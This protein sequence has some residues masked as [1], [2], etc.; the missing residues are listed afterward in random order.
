MNEAEAKKITE[1][2][3]IE[4]QEADDT[5]NFDLYTQRFEHQYIKDFTVERFNSDTKAMHE[6]NGMSQ[7]Y[8]FL[9]VLRTPDFKGNVIFRTVWKGIY[10]KRDAIIEFA[11][12]QKNQQWH[13]I[14]SAVY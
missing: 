8:E 2:Y 11:I 14:M 12:Y 5:G 1:Q 10:E 4:M 3:L 9:A 6:R 13:V 7:G